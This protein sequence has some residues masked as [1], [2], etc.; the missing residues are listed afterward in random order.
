MTIG[1]L[2]FVLATQSERPNWN[3][4]PIS[5]PRDAARVSFPFLMPSADSPFRISKSLL[6]WVPRIDMYPERPGRRAVRLS[7]KAAS[8]ADFDLLQVEGAGIPC[9]KNVRQVY[10]HGYLGLWGRVEQWAQVVERF[11]VCTAVVSKDVDP[12]VLSDFVKSLR[13]SKKIAGRSK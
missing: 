2:T 1:L 12:K 7:I 13:L 6:V 8:G 3:P 10:S 11:G 5:L 9:Q 4:K